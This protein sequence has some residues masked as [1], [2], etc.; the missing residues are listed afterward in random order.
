MHLRLRLT[1]ATLSVVTVMGVVGLVSLRINRGIQGDVEELARTA[2]LPIDPS[3]IVGQALSIEGRPGPDGAFTATSIERL[4]A[5]RRPK[6]RGALT[7]VDA[8]E[9]TVVLLGRVIR[10]DDDTEFDDSTSEG[11]PFGSLAVG[12]RVEIGARVESDGHWTARK[13]ETRAIKRTDKLKGTITAI[14]ARADGGQTL[15]VSGL[16]IAV[17]A[18]A[19][20]Q[21]PRGPLYRMENAMQMT[22]AVQECLAAA[23]E[24]VKE[25]YREA[26]SAAKRSDGV[27]EDL[28]DRVF[29]AYETFAE[30]LDE[31]R[32]S[33]RAELHESGAVFASDSETEW[34]APLEARRRTFEE[35]VRTFVPLAS[36]DLDA[37]ER[38]LKERIEPFLR[39]EIQPRAHAYH[40]HTEEMLSEE[41]E[42][43]SARSAEAARVELFTNA[44]GVV[45][46]LALGLVVSRSIARPL[47]QLTDAAERIG[48]GELA[49]RVASDS[50]DEV[51]ILARAFN[52]MAEALAASTVSLDQLS[53]VIDSMAGAL[54]VLGPDG[55]ITRVNPAAAALVGFEPAELLGRPFE[56][57]SPDGRADGALAAMA[58]GSVASMER[59]FVRRDATSVPVAFSGAALRD[60]GGR[61][62]GFVCLA[63]DLSSHKRMEA[64]LRRSLGEKEV[65][66][67]EVHHRVK[68]NLQVVSSLL[69]LQSHS[70]TDPRA[71]ERFQESQD[72]IHAL[73]FVHDLLYS[74][75][76]VGSIDLAPYLQLLVGRLKE[77][78]SLEPSRVKFDLEVDEELTLDIDRAQVCGLI[79][80]ELVTNAF[81]H[82]FP[83][84]SS[85]HVGIACRLAP[86][87]DVVLEVRD[88]GRGF[89]N[90]TDVQR[91][92]GL[93]LVETLAAQ[94]GGR[95]SS[96]GRR[97]AAYRIE[98]PYRIAVHAA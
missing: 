93:E 30:S 74:S 47:S 4:P 66:L 25:R 16:A 46:A 18:D 7:A 51:G 89:A 15:D 3:T 17:D 49:T 34:L 90:V 85:G 94:L 70:V 13:V 56:E 31:S 64:D 33:E 92:I 48:R 63:Q 26:S 97:G 40:R 44:A 37:A 72:R 61:V 45:L 68:N 6:L 21:T 11:D 88:D 12:T 87:G 41:L 43:I 91:S 14:A 81:K 23:H 27:I 38:L 54:L 29:D 8:S 5:T 10:V 76:N 9:R 78:Y 65:L 86:N 67:R 20:I 22:L 96:D 80:N 32:A 28:E 98:F 2:E 39:S 77:S 83:D 42:A 35:H 59:R 53:G 52:R 69:A 60:E 84:G 82:A 75:R 50:A 57:L 58:R 36:S 24:L 79:V 95:L 62:R 55:R 19:R 71:L 73:V 1:L